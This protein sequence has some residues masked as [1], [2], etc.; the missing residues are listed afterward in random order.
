MLALQTAQQPCMRQLHRVTQQ[1]YSCSWIAIVHK[2]LQAAAADIT[3][4]TVAA[5]VGLQASPGLNDAADAAGVLG[6]ASAAAVA[7]VAPLS[8][9]AAVAAAAQAV[10]ACCVHHS[11]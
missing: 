9:D 6:A 7:A 3:A 1:P 5:V 8:Q 10:D 11:E 4:Q 2:Q